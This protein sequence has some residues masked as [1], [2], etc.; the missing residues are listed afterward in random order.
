LLEEVIAPEFKKATGIEVRFI[1][2]GT[3]AAI[4]DAKNG[5]ADAIFV[6]A[7]AKELEF[8]EEGY[9]VNR[10]V[11][12]YN[13]FV[14]VG[15]KDDPAGIKG[16]NPTE[17]MKRIAE[18]GKNGKA[19]WVSR[20]DYSGTNVK[21][22]KLW[23]LAGFDYDSIK[24]ES[25]VRITGSGMGKTLL[26]ADNAKAYTL[27]DTGTFLKYRDLVEL[28]KLV[29]EGE[30]LIN[31]YSFIVVNPELNRNFDGAMK[32]LKWLSSEEGQR[33][34][35][36]F[37]EQGETLFCP[38]SSANETTYEWVIKYGFFKDGNIITEC[39]LKFRKGAEEVIFRD[40]TVN[41]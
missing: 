13:F 19:I 11:I 5:A 37:E 27:S 17:A 32:L 16:L 10:K 40:V 26:Y 31:I 18:A 7:P 25:W 8:M 34:I 20:G 1:A 39:P 41:D 35:G 29:S 30:E 21:E 23:N 24:N 6:H 22:M 2:K 15:P 38:V 14:I 28:E 4:Q 33:L 3:G 12:A 9:G 36:S